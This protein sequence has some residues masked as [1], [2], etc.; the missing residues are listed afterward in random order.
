MNDKAIITDLRQRFGEFILPIEQLPHA[1]YPG[2]I[3]NVK[4]IYLGCDP[5][6]NHSIE[7]PYVFAH[8][9]NLKVFNTF[10]KAHTF[11]LEQIGLNWEKVYS[12]NLCRNYFKIETAKNRIWKTVAINY[13][14]DQL[15]KE[16]AMFDSKI[17]VLLTSQVLLQVL[18]IGRYENILAPDFYECK[19][20]IPIPA[21]ESKLNRDLIPLYRGKSPQFNV[22]YHLK[23]KE[24]QNYREEIIKYF[25]DSKL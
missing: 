1:Y 14:V 21:Q 12:Q 24:W 13:W 11:Q 22:S 10:I 6:N 7:L 4:A 17:P 23:N 19:V 20:T 3:T 16:L 5:S 2:G 18:A 15:N 25:E 9:C 8:N